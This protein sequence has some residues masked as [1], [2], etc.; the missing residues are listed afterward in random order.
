MQDWVHFVP[1]VLLSAGDWPFLVAPLGASIFCAAVGLSVAAVINQV[2]DEAWDL[3]A[4]EVFEATFGLS[5]RFLKRLVGCLVCLGLLVAFAISVV[6]GVAYIVMVL[7]GW[8]YSAGPRW[9]RVPV[10]GTTM[11]ALVFAPLA[12]LGRGPADPGAFF[13]FACA[14]TLLLLQNQLLHEIAHADSD[15]LKGIRTTTIVV[16]GRVSGAAAA[17]LGLAAGIVMIGFGVRR[18]EPVVTFSGFG[19]A[20][21][22]LAIGIGALSERAD[23]STLRLVHRWS[24]FFWGGVAW[25]GYMLPRYAL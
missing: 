4:P 13:A 15:R 2:K 22:S 9:K 21:L 7:A 10:L 19:L 23:A 18:G 12:F 5:F 24:A 25:L 14:F 1:L 20:L 6:A 16:G 3:V 17:L 11:N 8:S